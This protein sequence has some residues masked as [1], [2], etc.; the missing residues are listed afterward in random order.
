MKNLKQNLVKNFFF[1][2][3]LLLAGFTYAQDCKVL[4]ESIS[5]SYTG[6]CKKGRA[7]GEGTAK[8]EDSYTGEFKKG[9]PHGFGK[10]TWADGSMYE[11]DF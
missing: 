8:G 1:V 6:D 5:G 7:H 4:K 3:N 9:L 11:G 2:F 10:Y